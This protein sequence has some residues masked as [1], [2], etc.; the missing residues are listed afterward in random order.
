MDLQQAL[1]ILAESGSEREKAYAVLA[2]SDG[3]DSIKISLIHVNRVLTQFVTGEIDQDDLEDWAMLL[4]ARDEFECNVVEDY[5]YALNN[6]ELMGGISHTTVSA[7]AELLK[8]QL[9][10]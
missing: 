1:Q 9:K 7:M 8:Q 4:D 6:P 5:L 2:D 10:T 3:T